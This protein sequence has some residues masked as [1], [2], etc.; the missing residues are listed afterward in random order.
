LS[1]ALSKLGAFESG[2]TGW[3]AA[4]AATHPPLALRLEALQVPRPDDWEYQEEELHGP[5]VGEFFRM[6]GLGLRR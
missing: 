2:R 6:L 1:S 3:E 4:M 5:T